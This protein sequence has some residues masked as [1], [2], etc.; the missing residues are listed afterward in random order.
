MHASFF[1]FVVFQMAFWEVQSKAAH[2]I[3]NTVTRVMR[4]SQGG[5]PL[6][7]FS[8][9]V[10][11]AVVALG[12]FPEKERKNFISVTCSILRACSL[13][14]A[15]V[16][17]LYHGRKTPL[18]RSALFVLWP[19]VL[20]KFGVSLVLAVIMMNCSHFFWLHEQKKHPEP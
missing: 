17:D 4:G 1:A 18:I 20:A 3:E 9:P 14:F 5:F 6:A 16:Q 12:G 10:A 8:A 15:I 19:A 11:L 13:C 2:V 7:S